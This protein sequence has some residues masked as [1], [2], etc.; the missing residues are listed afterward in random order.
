MMVAHLGQFVPADYP[1][2]VG[3]YLMRSGQPDQ[4]LS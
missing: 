4:D 3:H 1:Q 2:H